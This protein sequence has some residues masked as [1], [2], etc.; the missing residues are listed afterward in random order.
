MRRRRSVSERS[1]SGWGTWG[2]YGCLV[3]A[4]LVGSSLARAQ[5][6]PTD[7]ATVA[8]LIRQAREGGQA[9][10]DTSS[11]EVRVFQVRPGQWLSTGVE[12]KKGERFQVTATG[13]VK[14]DASWRNR[15]WG[16]NGFYWLGF[17]AYT[18]KGQVSERLLVIGGRWSGKAPSDGELKFGIT[19]TYERINAEDAGFTGAFKV[20]VTLYRSKR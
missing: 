11:T 5:V 8:S 13:R 7:S 18:L 17:S 1:S 9:A 19:R 16:P 4:L 2:K 14:A 12:L 10:V 3:L 20:T 6:P 15:E